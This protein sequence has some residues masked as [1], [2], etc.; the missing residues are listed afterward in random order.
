MRTSESFSDLNAELNPASRPPAT[1]ASAA[2]TAASASASKANTSSLTSTGE[3]Q[4]QQEKPF[5]LGKWGSCN[6]ALRVTA[7][8]RVGRIKRL[9]HIPNWRGSTLRI[10]VTLTH[11]NQAGSLSHTHMLCV[12][13]FCSDTCNPTEQKLET[14]LLW[15]RKLYKLGLEIYDNG[16]KQHYQ[17]RGWCIL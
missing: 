7:I 13:S 16:I 10:T 9:L 3:L 8:V 12:S 1:R 4:Q 2:S 11:L 14:T 15:A 6:D 5:G 17:N